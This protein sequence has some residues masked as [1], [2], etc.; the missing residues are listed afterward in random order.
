MAQLDPPKNKFSWGATPKT[1]YN[2]ANR[3]PTKEKRQE[4]IFSYIKFHAVYKIRYG[5][6]KPYK[7]FSLRRKGSVILPSKT[8]AT[9]GFTFMHG[10]TGVSTFKY[11]IYV[12]T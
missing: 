9:L 6:D 12:G 10:Y 8:L 5:N 1:P 2:I 7:H 4:I 3:R 11:Q